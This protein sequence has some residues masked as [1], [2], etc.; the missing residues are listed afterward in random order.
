MIT[1]Y[2]SDEPKPIK[3]QAIADLASRLLSEPGIVP[4]HMETYDIVLRPVAGF[5]V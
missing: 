2:V 1:L 4:E 5:D 3:T